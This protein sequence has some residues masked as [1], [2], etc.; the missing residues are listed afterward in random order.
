MEMPVMNQQGKTETLVSAALPDETVGNVFVDN[1]RITARDV[2]VFYGD[3]QAIDRV[4]LDIAEK[5]VISLH[6]SF[7]LRQVDISAL[8]EPDE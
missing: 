7:R 6:R 5:Q 2:N 3:K 4:T 1:P 8:P